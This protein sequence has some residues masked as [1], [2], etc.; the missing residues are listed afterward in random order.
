MRALGLIGRRHRGQS[1]RRR[2]MR[3]CLGIGSPASTT[4]SGKDYRLE[5]ARVRTCALTVRTEETQGAARER[6]NAGEFHRALSP[7]IR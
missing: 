7:P 2:F 3:L 6:A 4:R 1:I 5:E